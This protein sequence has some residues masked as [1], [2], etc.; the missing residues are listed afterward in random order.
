MKRMLST[1]LT[2]CLLLGASAALAEDAPVPGTIVR[3]PEAADYASYYAVRTPEEIL[4]PDNDGVLDLR[5]TDLRGIDLSGQGEALLRMDFDSRTIWPDVLPEGVDIE[6]LVALGMDPGC[7][8]RAVHE[9]GVTGKGIGIGIIDLTL[10]CG[11]AEYADRLRFYEETGPHAGIAEA[12]MHGAAVSSIALGETVGVAPD[13]LLYFIAMWPTVDLPDGGWARDCVPVADAIDRMLAL[14]EALPKDE[15]IRVI[16]ISVGWMPDHLG[17]AEME[18]ALARA[19]AAGVAVITVNSFFKDG[20]TVLGREP[21]SDPND[22]ASALRAIFQGGGVAGAGT[23]VPTDYRC[24]ASPIG[25]EDY[26]YYTVGGASW[27]VPY[28]AGLYAL[29]LEVKPGLSFDSFTAAVQRT[30]AP[31]PGGKGGGKVIDAVAL[32]TQ[33]MAR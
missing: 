33:M 8:V 26:A 22:P 7:G 19:E 20:Y 14:N 28:V 24:V 3:R 11:H 12:E 4:T 27:A 15:R 31:I 9:M 2:I 30:A 5:S 29:A 13:A 6:R 16:S 18:A 21:Y 23:H 1:L 25:T 17:V 32:F 10:L